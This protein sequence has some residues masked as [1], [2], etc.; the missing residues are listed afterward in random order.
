VL[1][2]FDTKKTTVFMADAKRVT[3]LTSFLQNVKENHLLGFVC[4][5]SELCRL[6]RW[7]VTDAK[8]ILLG[9]DEMISEFTEKPNRQM[10]LT[11]KGTKWILLKAPIRAST[12][13][14]LLTVY[15]TLF[16]AQ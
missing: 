16:Q 5:L 11:E 14:A 2:E 8:N 10:W 12:Y 6:L 7:R 4:N 13:N 3:Q 1:F 15:P 9:S